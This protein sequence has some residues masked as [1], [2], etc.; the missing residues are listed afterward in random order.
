MFDKKKN[1]GEGGTLGSC[2]KKKLFSLKKFTKKENKSR[3]Y[4]INAQKFTFLNR[5]KTISP[6]LIKTNKQPTPRGRSFFPWSPP[7]HKAY[8]KKYFGSKGWWKRR[9]FANTLIIP[10]SNAVYLTR[11]VRAQVNIVFSLILSSRNHNTII[12]K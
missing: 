2:S 5:M 8:C 9:A 3:K 7:I 11:P 12:V 4:P 1:S 6:E 10:F